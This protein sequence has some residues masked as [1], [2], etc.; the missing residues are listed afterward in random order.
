M[1][2]FKTFSAFI[3]VIPAIFLCLPA[4]GLYAGETGLYLVSTGSGDPENITFKAADTIKDSDIVFC[5]EKT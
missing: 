5:R 2:R 1:N 3:L 4:G